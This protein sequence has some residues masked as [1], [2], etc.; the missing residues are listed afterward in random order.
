MA[1]MNI[2][3]TFESKQIALRE[4]IFGYLCCDHEI[5]KSECKAIACKY[6]R[7]YVKYGV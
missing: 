7:K 5:V 3:I 4:K 6:N 1:K 2:K